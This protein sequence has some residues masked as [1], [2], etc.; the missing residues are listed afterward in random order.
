LPAGR[1]NL[2]RGR[3]ERAECHMPLMAP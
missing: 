3:K 2:A 1:E